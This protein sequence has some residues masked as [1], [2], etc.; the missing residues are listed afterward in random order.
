MRDHLA[1][2]VRGSVEETLKALLQKE[3]DDLCQARRYEPKAARKHASRELRAQARDE[4]RCSDAALAEAAPG[5]FETAIIERYRRR[6][7][8]SRK[9]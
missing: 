9:S 5:P 3:A 7:P 6:D 4:G 8:W 2:I 1:Q